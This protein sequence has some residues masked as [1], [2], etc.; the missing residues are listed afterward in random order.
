MF[1]EATQTHYYTASSVDNVNTSAHFN[2]RL[3]NCQI[4]YQLEPTLAAGKNHSLSI[5]LIYF[6]LLGLIDRLLYGTS[7]HK[8][9]SAK[10]CC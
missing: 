10:K 1:T 6:I 9:I 4:L 3:I 7:A 8:A 2:S 5:Y